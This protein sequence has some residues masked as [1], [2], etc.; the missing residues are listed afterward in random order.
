M[1]GRWPLALALLAPL[2]CRSFA[3]KDAGVR[4]EPPRAS[5]PVTW[6]CTGSPCPWGASMTGQAIV[7]AAAAA[8]SNRLGYTASA[9][10]YLAAGEANGMTI[11]VSAGA[12]T[13]YAGPLN[14]P[15]HRV[16]ASLTP[17]SPPQLVTGVAPGEVVSVLGN[18]PFTFATAPPPPGPALATDVPPGQ[19]VRS[20]SARWHCATSTCNGEPWPGAVIPWPAWAAVQGNGRAGDQGRLVYAAG[21][22]RPLYPYMGAWANGCRITA[23]SGRAEVVEWRHGDESWRRTFLNPGET[24]VVQLKPPENGALIEAPEGITEFSVSIEGC[25]PPKP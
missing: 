17:G 10:I 2:A 24:H 21:S 5:A 4:F 19:I 1:T 7:W 23:R 20:V 11:S 15:T 16:L 18:D 12:A 8:A 14:T 13:L 3:G 6:A 25:T 9:P 22:G